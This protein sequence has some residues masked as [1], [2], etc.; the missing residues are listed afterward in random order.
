MKKAIVMGTFDTFHNGHYELLT[1]G[2]KLFDK[3]IIEIGDDS[4]KDN[5]FT[6][7]ERKKMI[8]KAMA[9]YG[10]RIE[11]YYDNDLNSLGEICHKHNAPFVLRG[12]KAGRTFDE[13]IRIQNICKFMAKE[14]YNE[15]I[16]FVHKVTS[17]FDFRGS[18]V[19]KTYANDKEILKKL[20]P[21]IL[22]DCIYER[23]KSRES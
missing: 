22:V 7:E 8:L 10:D 17:D 4:K 21:E 15:E 1:Y 23:R 2:L 19:V 12:I 16:E 18:S 5:W 3:L 9:E 20:V 14:K 11:V 13:E 6:K